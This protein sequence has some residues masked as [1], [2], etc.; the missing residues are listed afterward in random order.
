MNY[1]ESGGEVFGE[2]LRKILEKNQKKLQNMGLYQFVEGKWIAGWWFQIFF[3][4]TPTWG[5]DLI[6]LIFFKWVETTNQ[7]AG[8]YFEM[9]GNFYQ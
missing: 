8:C 7:I 4:F 2:V 5:N 3:I 1:W 9:W 6:W